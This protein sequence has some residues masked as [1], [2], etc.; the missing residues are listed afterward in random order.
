V[1]GIC[2]RGRAGK[3]GSVQERSL[4]ECEGKKKE[5]FRRGGGGGCWG[6][7]NISIAIGYIS[8]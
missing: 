2:R 5:D 8:F 1:F 3:R 7:Q 6:G 4:M